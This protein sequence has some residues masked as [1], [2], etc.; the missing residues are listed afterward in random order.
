MGQPN[1]RMVT[2]R[3]KNHTT[4]IMIR[5]LSVALMISNSNLMLTLQLVIR[6]EAGHF[7]IAFLS[8]NS[9]IR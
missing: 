1:T 2:S 7:P 4:S 5:S 8:R 3:L 6:T 9:R